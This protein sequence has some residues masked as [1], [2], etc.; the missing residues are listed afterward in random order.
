MSVTLYQWTLAVSFSSSWKSAAHSFL[1]KIIKPVMIKEYQ[2]FKHS[3][4][5]CIC[6]QHTLLQ[7]RM[8][9]NSPVFLEYSRST[10]FVI[11][12]SYVHPA[13]TVTVSRLSEKPLDNPEICRQKVRNSRQREVSFDDSQG[14]RQT[15]K[16]AEQSNIC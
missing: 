16:Q 8:C 5:V 1:G 3:P 7:S 13:L 10:N 12:F 9:N 2:R 11:P 6:S 4:K 15:N 14:C